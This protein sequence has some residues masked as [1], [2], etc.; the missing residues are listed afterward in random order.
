MTLVKFNQP[1][2]KFINGWIENILNEF[3]LPFEKKFSGTSFMPSVN[4]KETPDAYYI[5]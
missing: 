3:S 1:A 2:P 5:E 4:I